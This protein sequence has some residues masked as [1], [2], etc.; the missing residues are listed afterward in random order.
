[1]RNE[2]GASV[3]KNPTITVCDTRTVDQQVNAI[4]SK[5]YTD[6]NTLRYFGT[7]FRASRLDEDLRD[8][9]IMSPF[10]VLELI[11]QLATGG[12]EEAFSAIQAIPRVHN[13]A[14]IG[15]LPWSDDLI[16]QTVFGLDPEEDVITPALNNA[17][18]NSLNAT[19][20]TVLHHDA[21]QLRNLLIRAKGVAVANFSALLN[22]WRSE[23][24]I[25][26]EAHRTIFASSIA[27]RCGAPTE[28]V[29]V[30]RAIHLLNAFY[31]FQ[32]EKLAIA[33]QHANYNA[34][35]RANDLYDAEQLVY[36]SD[37][38]LHFLTSDGGFNRSAASSQFDR[39]HIA[40][41][42]SLMDTA[43]ASAIIRD[44]LT[45]AE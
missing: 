24:P 41:P 36:L 5:I 10:S 4:P 31:I 16:R 43:Q 26:H 29:D 11:A 44:I 45:N 30:N 13:A 8:Q 3:E 19:T 14:A 32:L 37:P 39:I 42:A 1:M 15:L 35:R 27:R 23:G 33:A 34:A 7:A 38:T 18:N 25:T 17:V 22:S 20:P 9:M 28:D 40:Q 6:T 21:L 12:V 2:T